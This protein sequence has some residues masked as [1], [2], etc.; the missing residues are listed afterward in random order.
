MRDRTTR[1]TVGVFGSL[2]QLGLLAALTVEAARARL[3][4]DRIAFDGVL[5]G[6]PLCQAPAPLLIVVR[7]VPM[8]AGCVTRMMGD[9]SGGC[10]RA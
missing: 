5:I 8:C 2:D 7:F 4:S 1:D 10:D 6:C 3:L 9:S